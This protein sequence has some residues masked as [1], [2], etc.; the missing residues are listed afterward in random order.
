MAGGRK[1]G[2]RTRPPNRR[3]KSEEELQFSPSL[4]RHFD[5]PLPSSRPGRGRGGN[6]RY[7]DR[8]RASS[9]SVGHRNAA[10]ISFRYDYPVIDL[11]EG[12]GAESCEGG[13]NRASE[14]SDMNPIVLVNSSETS[15]VAFMDQTPSK[16]PSNAEYV[17]DYTS[18][19]V[20]DG[21][22]HQDF[23]F[24]NDEDNNSHKGLGFCDEMEGT[25]TFTG[26]SSM[27]MEE[28]HVSSS[29]YSSHLMGMNADSNNIVSNLGA[30]MAK[31]ALGNP[32]HSQRNSGFLA[33]GGM[34]LYTEDLLADESDE[35]YDGGSPHDKSSDL[36]RPG[37]SNES[38]G[39]DSSAFNS[40]SDIDEAVAE[41]Y[42]EGIGGSDGILKAKWLAGVELYDNN[43]ASSSSS[44][45]ETTEKLGG[46]ALQEASMEYGMKKPQTSEMSS[47]KSPGLRATRDD[48][49]PAL[50]Q[51]LLVK[52]H[53][54]FTARKNKKNH[55]ARFSQ[56]WPL[57][58]Q[59]SKCFRNFPGEKKK[60]RN[61]V[62]AL[63]R[64]ERMKLR[65]VDLEE[66]NSKLKQM[67]LEEVDALS[68]QP[69][70]L[71]DCLQ[72]QRVA[73]V[74]GLR[75]G[76]QGYS[77]KRFVTVMR[78]V[79]TRLPSSDGKR[80]LEKLIGSRN[81]DEDFTVTPKLVKNI[82]KSTLSPLEH[83]PSRHSKSSKNLGTKSSEKKQ[84]RRKGVSL[85]DQ[86]VSFVSSGIMQ[87]ET[88]E[89]RT[90][91]SEEKNDAAGGHEGT[92]KQGTFELHTKGF[93]S[94]M[95]AK[96]GFVEGGGLGKDGQ[97]M[98]EPIEVIK[99][100][101]SL[102]LGVE[103]SS[104]VGTAAGND[105]VNSAR[106]R[107]GNSALNKPQ[108]VGAFEKHTKGF[109]SKMMAKMGFVEGMG[110]GKDSQGMVNPLVAVRRP[111]SQGLG[112]K[113]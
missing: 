32:S 48:W 69:M 20:L 53:R 4:S 66:I 3:S 85:V 19:L 87:S 96:M 22:S 95:M 108:M 106:N 54:M 89:S 92:S 13:N 38:S 49:E 28:H 6:V 60:H 25:P 55:V 18:N 100:P 2:K 94:K 113:G 78:T 16:K 1:G 84:S 35:E 107:S 37:D 110:L 50:D 83:R 36:S 24:C 33:I 82:M 43:K 51:S 30:K 75:S 39:S 81:E 56:S 109:G 29:N 79:Y 63:K 52:D 46:I 97:G 40:D 71:R 62:I 104:D 99:R 26:S 41:D 23:G 64:R 45:E 14:S 59:K 74:Y 105:V 34:K 15:A 112:A 42:I 76:C 111:K 88:I 17:Y 86:P 44:F 9:S 70:H 103:F 91:D 102:G 77:K 27:N 73:A 65:G 98:V 8:A 31:D 68:F 47:T 58:A 10:G 93:G 5:S 11:E 21:S 12:M 61:E 67:V 90:F 101:K 80:R 72:V 7:S 57:E